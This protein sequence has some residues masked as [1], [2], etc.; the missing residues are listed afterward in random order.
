MDFLDEPRESCEPILRD[1][2]GFHPLAI[3][4]AI[5]ESHVPKV[6]DWGAYLYLVLH[7]VAFDRSADQPLVAREPPLLDRHGPH[8]VL[9][10]A[11]Q[12][13]ALLEALAPRG[14]AR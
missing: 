3:D 7:A 4:D 10:C 6:D 8:E 2:F 1:T 9:E 14:G 13:A 5:Q 11:L 12:V